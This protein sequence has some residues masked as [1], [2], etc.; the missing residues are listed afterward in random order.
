MAGFEILPLDMQIEIIKKLSPDDLSN[1]FQTNRQFHHLCL[2]QLDP[3]FQQL[4]TQ[5]FGIDLTSDYIYITIPIK[6]SWYLTFINIY[7]DINRIVDSILSLLPIDKQYFKPEVVK[8]LANQIQYLI[9]NNFK[10]HKNSTH[11][12][13]IPLS[14]SIVSLLLPF[15]S[16]SFLHHIQDILPDFPRKFQS[17]YELLIHRTLI[18]SFNRYT[19]ISHSKSRSHSRP[20]SRSRRR[21]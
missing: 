6:G 2:H 12:R 5:L 17:H 19:S 1:L 14:S 11:N 21:F 9:I 18:T 10:L 4:T 16:P 7:N 20:K 15:I 13:F 3:Y 8:E